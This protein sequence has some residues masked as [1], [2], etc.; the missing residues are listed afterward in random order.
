MLILL[1]AED[2]GNIA[3]RCNRRVLPRANNRVGLAPRSLCSIRRAVTL[4]ADLVLGQIL[5]PAVIAIAVATLLT[6]LLIAHDSPVH[7]APALAPQAFLPVSLQHS[8]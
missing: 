5:Q 4:G 2:L 8:L 3:A 6:T 1:Q 7:P